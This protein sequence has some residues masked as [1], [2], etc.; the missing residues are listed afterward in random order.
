MEI[1]DR[2][3]EL[4]KEQ[5]TLVKQ[6]NDLSQQL[7]NIITRVIQIQGALDELQKL[8]Q[9]PQESQETQSGQV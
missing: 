6:Y 7:Q 9:E 5:E 8:V 2:I 3:A 4:L 1:R